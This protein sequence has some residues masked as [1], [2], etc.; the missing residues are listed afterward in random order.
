MDS[1]Q[2]FVVAPRA[3][4]PQYPAPCFVLEQDNWNDFG[5]QTQYHLTHYARDAAGRLDATSIPR[6]P[7]GRCS[8]ASQATPSASHRVDHRTHAARSRP[9][10]IAA[11]LQPSGRWHLQAGYRHSS[12]WIECRA[13]PKPVFD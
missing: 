11:Q 2:F 12:L 1:I 9:A 10:V 3:R 7:L 13:R 5:F 8:S 6:E 4:L